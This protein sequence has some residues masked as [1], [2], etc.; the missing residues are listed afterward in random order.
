MCHNTSKLDPLVA[1]YEKRKLALTG[2]ALPWLRVALCCR[3][4][5]V[6]ASASSSCLFLLPPGCLHQPPSLPR[7]LPMPPCADLVDNYISQKR[8]GKELKV[9]QVRPWPRFPAPAPV[10]PLPGGGPEAGRHARRARVI[11]ASG[12]TSTALP[13]GCRRA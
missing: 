1:E 4:H 8:R 6:L 11:T 5:A 10:R 7:P 12:L 3:T 9:K 13:R 2:A